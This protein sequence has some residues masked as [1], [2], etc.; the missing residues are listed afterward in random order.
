TPQGYL[1]FIDRKRNFFYTAENRKIFPHRLESVLEEERYISHALVTLY[2]HEILGI[3][4]VDPIRIAM[5]FDRHHEKCPEDFSFMVNHAITQKEIIGNLKKANQKLGVNE[6]ITL[7]FICPFELT[8]QN[9][10]LTSTQRIIRLPILERVGP[11]L[12]DARA[13]FP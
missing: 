11:Y 5:L 9:K 8:A 6:K 4:G 1:K 13:I 3:I 2:Q 7:Y 12:T 10:L